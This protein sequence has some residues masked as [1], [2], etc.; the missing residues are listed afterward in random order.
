MTHPQNSTPIEAIRN[1]SSAPGLNTHKVGMIFENSRP[2]MRPL[3]MS[4]E[5]RLARVRCV[6]RPALNQSVAHMLSSDQL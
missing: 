3:W 5:G 1:W 4:S 2:T 6:T